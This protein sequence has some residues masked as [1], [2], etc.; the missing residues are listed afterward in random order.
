[1][2]G[3]DPSLFA[4]NVGGLASLLRQVRGLELIATVLASAP[5]RYL[6]C[7][8]ELKQA[9]ILSHLPRAL[10]LPSPYSY[11]QVLADAT[12]IDAS[13]VALT[14]AQREVTTG[15]GGV[16]TP[17]SDAL[18]INST[19][20]GN[21]GTLQD[22]NSA[23]WA[24][25]TPSPTSDAPHRRLRVDD[26]S[27][28]H[29]RRLQSSSSSDDAVCATVR[30]TSSAKTT[31]TRLFL[32]VDLSNLDFGP[33]TDTGAIIAQRLAALL[34]SEG[35]SQ[36]SAFVTAYANCTG[37]TANASEA[38]LLVAAPVLRV[39][40]LPVPSNS[41]SSDHSGNG[42][43]LNNSSITGLFFGLFIAV[44]LAAAV[45]AAC[46][47]RTYFACCGCC[48]IKRREGKLAAGDERVIGPRRNTAVP[49]MMVAHAPA[50]VRMQSGEEVRKSHSFHS[51][52]Q[53]R[54]AAPQQQH[55]PHA[56]RPPPGAAAVVV[57]AQA[58]AKE[59]GQ[60]TK[61]PSIIY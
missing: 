17:A 50:P 54:R 34:S 14:G 22:G 57:V 24:S 18:Q 12:G 41:A 20:A 8:C 43:K 1:M 61:T 59:G 45:T 2:P 13:S 30:S 7:R 47:C 32:A 52:G 55:P 44:L 21:N 28:L 36:L 42:L 23:L 4:D 9:M 37:T 46:C 15:S 33:G 51:G 35:A 3:G 60:H 31:R 53:Q 11:P 39:G 10:T 27:L 58:G 5:K 6:A 56:V 19:S 48:G 49:V 40:S 29:A 38:I 25:A 16:F 26:S